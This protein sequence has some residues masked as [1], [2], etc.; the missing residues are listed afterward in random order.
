MIN[1]AQ[2]GYGI[3]LRRMNTEIEAKFLHVDHDSL[4]AKLKSVG[5]VCEQPKRLMRRV[6]IDPPALRSKEAF[7]RIRDEGNKTT[8]TY[9]R[10]NQLTVDGTTEIEI[11]ANDF[12][13]AV[14]LFDAAG[15]T[16]DSYQ[17]TRRETWRLGEVEILLD[18]WPWLDPYIEIEGQ[19]AEAVKT[20]AAQLGYDWNNAVFGGVTVVYKL[21]YPQHGLGE[22]SI[23]QVP[24]MKFDTPVPDILKG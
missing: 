13:K 12:E 23:T 16:H 18:E 21:Q 4:R 20:A 14:A 6:V 7:V 24:E 1:S 2:R 8:I 15:L 10:F 22:G 9:K 19:V 5:A 11:V 3:C 17:E